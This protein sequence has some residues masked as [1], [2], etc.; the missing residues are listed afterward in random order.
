ME[1][2]STRWRT[3]LDDALPWFGLAAFWVFAGVV[4]LAVVAIFGA[5]FFDR[6]WF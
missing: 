4:L 6:A 3:L 2:L 5:A 1:P